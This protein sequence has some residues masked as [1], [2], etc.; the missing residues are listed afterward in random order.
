MQE[1]SDLHDPFNLSSSMNY[2]KSVIHN[3][4]FYDFISFQ[5]LTLLEILIFIQKYYLP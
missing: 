2:F 5:D 3:K 4:S 1:R